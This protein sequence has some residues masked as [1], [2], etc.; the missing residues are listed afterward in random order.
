[1]WTR[2]SSVVYIRPVVFI[3]ADDDWVTA[4]VCIS[5]LLKS[6]LRF[7]AVSR[8]TKENTSKHGRA[9]ID[10]VHTTKIHQTARVCV[11]HLTDWHIV[12]HFLF[13]LANPKPPRSSLATSEHV[14]S[15]GWSLEQSV[16]MHVTQ[17]RWNI[18]TRWAQ[19][20]TTALSDDDTPSASNLQPT[21]KAVVYRAPISPKNTRCSRWWSSFQWGC[22]SVCV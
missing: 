17:M 11:S 14:I 19:A 6:K 4:S 22:S 15:E 8:E 18:H 5:V 9:V 16:N 2:P 1:M 13:Q 12:T 3:T 7:N 21:F 20:V 10:S